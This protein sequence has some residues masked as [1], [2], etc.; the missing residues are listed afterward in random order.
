MMLR[1]GNERVCGDIPSGFPDVVDLQSD[2]APRLQACPSNALTAVEIAGDL[3]KLLCSEWPAT[4]LMKSW[5]R[6]SPLG[7]H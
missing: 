1:P 4:Q 5:S 7:V 2:S 6:D 3:P